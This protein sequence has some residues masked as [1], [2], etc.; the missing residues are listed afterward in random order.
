[1]R[2][3]AVFAG[4][5]AAGIFLA[6]YLLPVS[7]L[8]PCA[9]AGLGLGILSLKLPWNQ[10]RRA[11]IACSA[12]ALALGYN[13]LYI[14]QVQT[15]AAAW[16]ET[17]RV[18]TATL[19]NY[20]EPSGFGARVT[21]RLEGVPGKAVYYG[22]EGLLD[23]V[24]GQTVTGTVLLRNAAH[25]VDEDITTFTSKGVFLLAYARGEPAAGPG[26]SGSLRWVPVRMCRAMQ[27]TISGI[28]HGDAAGFLTAVLTGE[29][30][31]LSEEAQT[32]LSEAGIYHI[33]AVSGMH[34][35]FLLGLASLLTGK[36]SRLR[37]L[38]AVPLL[39]FYALLTGG[40]PSVVRACIMLS[41]FT[42]GPLFRRE[43]D[44]PT[45]LAA[46]LFLILLQNPF[47][48]ASVSL[49]LSFAAMAGL[50]WLTPKLE[51]LLLGGRARG[52]FYRVIVSG[53][54][55]TMGAMVFTIPLSGWYFGSLAL[56]S[57][58][59][60]LLCLWAASGVFLLGLPA[61][62]AGMICLPIG[63]VA[64]V[65]A[66]LLANYILLAAKLMAKIPY[67]AVYFSNPYLKF[68]VAF[69]YLLFLCA[70]LARKA[71]SRKYV[72]AAVLAAAALAVTVKLGAARY[73][74]DLDALILNVGQGQSV[75]LS[76][77]GRFALVDCGSGNSW[78]RAGETAA[79]QLKSMGCRRLDY[80][81]LTHYDSDHVNG[82]TGLLA[83]LDAGVLLLPDYED[84]AGQRTGVLDAAEKNGVPV[85]FVTELETLSLG[86]AEITVFPPLGTEEDND[87][88]L[89]VLA[90]LEENDLLITGDMSASVERKLLE[91]YDLPDIEVLV[92]GHHGSK[93]STSKELLQALKPETVCVS[94]GSNRY[95][96]PAEETLKRIA[97][98]GGSICRTDL[99]GNIHLWWN[100]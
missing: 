79:W 5:F 80:I 14:R 84:D 86:Q 85:S 76:S 82:L 6:Q 11:V 75:L 66:S 19:C 37:A 2:R 16:A 12:L 56:I 3:L 21:V 92:A 58:L 73:S 50:L 74:N 18:M 30:A 69:A 62:C 61:V 91:S 52:K 96:H 15:P 7:W 67:H 26:T 33:M 22:D 100:S 20:A 99:Q 9:F 28:F 65:P 77:G 78:L 31:G 41:I 49:Q 27:T 51:A 83:R 68:W 35:M 24:P 46:A 54:S 70:Y 55:A 64:A 23:L 89:A 90:S 47:A 93:Y 48:A 39:V 32:A 72:L 71:K 29:R 63:A 43:S 40:S 34:C 94:S 53:F 45:S 10:R 1:M 88:G 25:I 60:N 57:P 4:A 44:G 42:A 38:A 17:E 13:W 95:G 59:T 36:R 8:L 97:R 81:L 98:E 87:K